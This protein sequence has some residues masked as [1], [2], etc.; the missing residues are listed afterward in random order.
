[1]APCQPAAGDQVAFW[2]NGAQTSKSETWQPGGAPSDVADGVA[3]AGEGGV[4]QPKAGTFGWVLPD[5][6]VGLV[7]F[8]GGTIEDA[9]SA[10]PQVVAFWGAVDGVFRGYVVGAPAFVNAAFVGK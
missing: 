3:L 6:G 4:Q 2:L 10:A 9:V 7:V 5:K 8:P 1:D